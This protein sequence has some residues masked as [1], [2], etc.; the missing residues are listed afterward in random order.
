MQH[1]APTELVVRTERIGL[2]FSEDSDILNETFPA[3]E[4]NYG[5][6]R[7]ALSGSRG[8]RIKQKVQE[9]NMRNSKISRLAQL[10]LLLAI[11]LVMAFTPLGYLNIGPLS[12]T[13]LVI[14]VVVGAV[15]LGSRAGLVLGLAFGLTS[16]AQCFGISA[17]GV[18]LMGIH[19]LYTV[20]ICIVPRVLVGLFSCLVFRA[21][22]GRKV[23][24]YAA[25]A[26][27][28]LTNSALFLGGVVVFFGNTEYLRAFGSNVL[29]IL[30]A[31]G[32]VNAVVEV[33]VCTVVGGLLGNACLTY[34]GRKAKK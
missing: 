5:R 13:F 10:A 17:F 28:S 20:L 14:P 16:F 18:A 3:G 9:N 7:A 22:Q 4:W 24:C 32:A 11:L 12:V 6:P 27:G 23:A 29:E 21:M 25:S 33:L 30:L 19:P 2:D 26:V 31:L 1:M 8:P 15:V 34:F